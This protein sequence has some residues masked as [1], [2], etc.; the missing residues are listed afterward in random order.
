MEIWKDI[1][2]YEGIYQVSNFGRVKS[3]KRTISHWRGGNSVIKERILKGIISDYLVVVLYKEGKQ[4][5]KKI[6]KLVAESFLNHKPC[7][8]NLV[9]N[10]IDFNKLNNNV[11]NL[12]IVTNRENCNHKHIKSSSKYTGVNWN[13]KDK[14]WHSSIYINGK[15]KYLGYFDCETKAHLAYQNKLKTL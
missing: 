14:K 8:M 1:K 13:K 9:V 11:S 12:E 3:L 5:T 6:H 4:K 7:G 2:D 15:L 10:H